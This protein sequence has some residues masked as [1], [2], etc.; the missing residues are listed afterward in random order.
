MLLGNKPLLITMLISSNSQ[1][2]N[3]RDILTSFKR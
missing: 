2:V 3:I 1:N